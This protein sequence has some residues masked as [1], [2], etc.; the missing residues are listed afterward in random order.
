ML[1]K[2]GGKK[3]PLRQLRRLKLPHCKTTHEPKRMGTP[4]Q[5]VEDHSIEAPFPGVTDAGP[6]SL[7]P[8]S[9]FFKNAGRLLN[10]PPQR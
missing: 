4:L 10:E 2:K 1:G 3:E 5:Q 8:A 9:L 7:L 6:P